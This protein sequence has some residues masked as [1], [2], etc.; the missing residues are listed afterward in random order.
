M[1]AGLNPAASAYAGLASVA[2][3]LAT[4]TSATSASPTAAICGRKLSTVTFTDPL[5]KG[6]TGAS[7]PRPRS[8]LT[9]A[10]VPSATLT[11]SDNCVS[12]PSASVNCATT[13]G[14]ATP[15]TD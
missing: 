14:L 11:I 9:V 7:D 5:V 6:A 12:E 10:C 4:P 3:S 1:A 8:A 15:S 13:P 2:R